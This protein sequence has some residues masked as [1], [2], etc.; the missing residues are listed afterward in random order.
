MFS[1]LDHPQGATLFLAKVI[2]YNV[3]YFVIFIGDAAAFHVYVYMS[4]PLQGSKS[5]AFSDED[6]ERVELCFYSPSVSSWQVLG[7]ILLYF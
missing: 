5:T 2:C 1:S 4:Y 3:N 6:K 7:R